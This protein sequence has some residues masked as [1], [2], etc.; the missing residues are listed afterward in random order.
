MAVIYLLFISSINFWRGGWQLGPRYITAMLPFVMVPVT[1]AIYQLSRVRAGRAVCVALVTTGVVVYAASCAEF[2]HFPEKFDNPLFE[3]TFRL[4]AD[5]L[6]PYNLGYVFGLRGFASLLPYLGVVI[7]VIGYLAYGPPN[8]HRTGPR[9][10]RQLLWAA[11]GL[12]GAGL[13]LAGYSAIDDG[14]PVAERAYQW[15]TTTF[16]S[17]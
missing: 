6:A 5:D 15:I 9:V 13:V 1:V 17:P 3:L 8:R 7:A 10:R 2:P 12:A 14:G 11:I 16:P 4:M